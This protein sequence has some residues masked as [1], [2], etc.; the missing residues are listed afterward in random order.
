[1]LEC[2]RQ[3]ERRPPP[4]GVYRPAGGGGHVNPGTS[5]APRTTHHT[6]QT[7]FPRLRVPDA[8]RRTTAQCPEALGR[9]PMAREVRR[10]N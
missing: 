3:A 9:G 5:H 2:K 4:L 8:P 1:M 6:T 10:G 7:P